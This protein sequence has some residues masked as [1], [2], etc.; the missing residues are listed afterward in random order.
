MSS[1]P[2]QSASSSAVD[3]QPRLDHQRESERLRGAVRNLR[4]ERS[5][6]QAQ[7][8]EREYVVGCNRTLLPTGRGLGTVAVVTLL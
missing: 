8:Q 5:A 6:L 7:L 1:P 3:R 2:A 4:A